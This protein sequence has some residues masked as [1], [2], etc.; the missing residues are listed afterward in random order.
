MRFPEKIDLGF[1][2]IKVVLVN[3]KQMAAEAECE[4]GDAPDGLWDSEIDTIFIGRW[5]N[6]KRKRHVLFHELVHA[7]VDNGYYNV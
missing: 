7:G 4:I 1:T 2:V 3:R 6:A 5:L